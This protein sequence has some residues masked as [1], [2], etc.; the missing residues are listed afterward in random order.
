MIC[1]Q[2]FCILSHLPVQHWE[3][4]GMTLSTVLDIQPQALLHD[5]EIPSDTLSLGADNCST[6][7]LQT[8]TAVFSRY[9]STEFSLLYLSGKPAVVI[10]P[11]CFH[12]LWKKELEFWVS[13][14][15]VELCAD[16]S[17]SAAE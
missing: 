3:G 9:S 5:I 15:Y 17:G 14:L 16:S 11:S 12:S 4:L 10:C 13:C 7:V 8:A 1:Y 2:I 6:K